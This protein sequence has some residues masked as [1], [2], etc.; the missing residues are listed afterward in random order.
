MKTALIINPKS[1]A[2]NTMKLWREVKSQLQNR[3]PP[4]EVFMTEFPRHAT[5]ITQYLAE[6]KYE[7]IIVM[8]GDG[9][10]H[11][12]VNG[13]FNEA[14]KLIQPDI[15]I[16]VL[17]SGRG[18][19][20]ARTIE[21]PLDSTQNINILVDSKVKMVDLGKVTYSTSKGPKVE[22]FLN[23]FSYILGGDVCNRVSRAKTLLPPSVMYFT[24]SFTGLLTANSANL[25]IKLPNRDPIRGDFYNVFAMNGKYSGGGMNWAPRAKVDDGLLEVILV[26]KMSKLKLMLSGSKV[27]EGTFD[28]INGIESYQAPWIQITSD[29]VRAMELDGEVLES[30]E[31]KVE[32]LP[33]I[34]QFIC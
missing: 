15:K 23:S 25:E 30:K 27:Y 24:A 18:C 8:G 3:L 33:K 2:G 4:F 7:R 22:Y 16:G 28:Q 17:N 32:I 26:S 9:S 21:T 1:A 31:I 29:Q 10:L 34:L 5:E 6:K 19:D 12:V 13:L 11:E 20:F 14:G